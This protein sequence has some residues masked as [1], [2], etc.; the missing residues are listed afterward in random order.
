MSTRCVTVVRIVGCCL[1]LSLGAQVF[2]A[3]QPGTYFKAD[4]SFVQTAG[5]SEAG[6]LGAK[7]NFTQNWLRSGFTM[8]AGGV[9]AQTKETSRTAVGP[10]ASDYAIQE[11]SL[12]KTSAENFFADAQLSYRLTESFYWFGK[13]SWAR[14]NPA[15][16]KSRFMEMTGFGYDLSKR[17]DV[18][19]K[20]NAAATL[21]QENATVE[22]AAAKKN[23]PGVQL[24]YQYKQ[25][26]SSTATVTHTLTY[27]QPF[28]PSSDFRIDGQGGLE[29][30]I[31][32]SGTLALKVDARVQYDNM[33]ALEELEL[34]RSNGTKTNLKVTNPLNKLDGQFTVALVINLSRKGG[35]TSVRGR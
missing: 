9:R 12:S 7:A 28:S 23:F 27:D 21:T 26:V 30:S 4:F 14:D 16:V 32:R 19:F 5:N 24:S 11:T 22:N 25:K 3:D 33:P 6:T 35:M 20:L 18:E 17:D 2:A 8:N 31:T 29:V 13:A 15:G 10:S 34:I 1:A